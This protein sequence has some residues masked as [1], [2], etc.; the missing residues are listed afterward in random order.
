MQHSADPDCVHRDK[1]SIMKNP[2]EVFNKIEDL[3]QEAKML[4]SSF[5]DA[6]THSKE[7]QEISE[8]AKKLREAKKTAED[9]VKADF[10][11]EVNRLVEIKNEIGELNVQLSDIALSN[12]MKGELVEVVGKH[13]EQYEPVLT[14]KFKRK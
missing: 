4:R 9:A 13:E 2:Q 5:R 1:T 14:V 8:S 7:L 11:P 12:I 10:G 6:L 3:K